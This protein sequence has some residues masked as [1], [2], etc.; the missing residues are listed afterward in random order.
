MKVDT[1]GFTLG[2]RVLGE[3]PGEERSMQDRDLEFELRIGNGDGE[4]A[5]ILVVDA[6]EVD[7]FV[8]VELRESE[9]L[10][11]EEVVGH[12]E[13]DTR[14]VRRV[15]RV[16]HEVTVQRLDERDAGVLAPAAVRSQFVGR[17]RFEGDTDAFDADRFASIVEEHSED[18][19]S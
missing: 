11:R 8:G 4:H 14:S 12:R 6:V 19:D 5:G 7:P 17:L 16:G 9:A 18:P 13:R 2:H 10:P 3:R 1:S 15:R